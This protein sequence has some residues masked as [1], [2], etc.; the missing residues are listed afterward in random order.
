MWRL[1]T[2]AQARTGRQRLDNRKPVCD[3]V[4]MTDR[5]HAQLGRLLC[6]TL[7]TGAVAACGE[8]RQ[9][10]RV[11]GD[12]AAPTAALVPA[13]LDKYLASVLPTPR[14]FLIPAGTD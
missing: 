14:R 7:A 8:G 10:A 12:C 13:A 3:N 9:S 2:C 5:R 1:Y 6:M 11:G 4:P